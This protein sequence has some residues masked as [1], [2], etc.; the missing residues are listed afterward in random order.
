VH[1]V[2][3]RSFCVVD[4]MVL[5]EEVRS[6]RTYL[7]RA[8]GPTHRSRT[9]ATKVVSQARYDIFILIAGDLVSSQ[10]IL[11]P[12]PAKHTPR[13]QTPLPKTIATMRFA[14][15]TVAMA[16]IFAGALAA[17]SGPGWY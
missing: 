15:I 6:D 13:H 10:L 7:V 8:I 17:P 14:I 4:N 9:S 5:A 12:E 16:L 2:A 11:A 1:N 3:G